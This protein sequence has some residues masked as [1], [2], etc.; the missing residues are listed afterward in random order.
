M[1][2]KGFIQHK[3][4]DADDLTMEEKIEALAGLEKLSIVE[5]KNIVSETAILTEAMGDDD[6]AN[7]MKHR[8]KVRKMTGQK[9]QHLKG[10]KA[11]KAAKVAKAKT[12]AAK[13]GGTAAKSKGWGSKIAA[14]IKKGV[15]SY[16]AKVKAMG[17]N[18]AKLAKVAAKTM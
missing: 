5:M 16:G 2:I 12:A 14:A 7:Y 3:I 11:A 9:P 17:P 13:V 1:Y 15:A 8:N 18:A 4:Y 6:V 10:T